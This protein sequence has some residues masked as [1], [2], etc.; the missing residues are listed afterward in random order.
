MAKKQTIV[1]LGVLG[2]AAVAA[3]GG[4]V[5][6]TRIQSPADMAAR[7]APPIPSPILV[8]VEK[9]VLSSDVV[10]RGTA[11]FGLPQPISIV[12][13]VLK[14]DAG[15]IATLPLPNTQFREGD[16]LLTASG[17]PLLI[18]QGKLPAYRDMVPGIS[19]E[20]VR[21]L[22][23]GLARLGFYHGPIDGVYTPQTSVAVAKWYRSK[24]RDPF[25]ST[26]D[27]LV[28]VSTLE[29]AWADA[30][31]SELTAAAAA[32]AAV[33]AVEA[34]RASAERNNKAAAAELAAKM[35]DQ[36]RFAVNPKTGMPLGVEAARAASDEKN[37]AAAAE[38]EA[39]I[40]E[41]ALIALDPRQP[42]TT[43][44]AADA[45][46][47]VARAML[48]STQLDGKMAVQAA[49]R[50]V[51]LVAEQFK[52]AE[53]AVKSVR[54]DGEMAVRSAVNALKVAQFDAK[55]TADRTNR[56][57]ADLA[58]AR[59]KL[60]VQVPVD[61]IVFIPELPVR[62]KEVTA[63]VGDPAKGTVLSVTDNKLAI[64]SSLPI[65]TAP[66]VKP[67]MQ[68]AI[69]EQALGVKAKGVVEM[70]ADTPGTRGVDG[71]HIYFAVR[72]I[73]TSTRQLEGF[74]VRLTIPVKST[75]G[76]VTVVP[77]SALSL[78]SD[79]KSRVQVK[80]KGALEYI[81]VQP[82][83]SADGYVEVIPVDRTLEPGQLVVVGYENPGKRTS[84]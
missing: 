34:A 84:P 76:A 19:G 60:G 39:R 78:A 79:G 66:L 47:E 70:V 36:R 69:D 44:K 26:P 40:A 10:T 3:V 38:L 5:A 37:R 24:G 52:L 33:P 4:W 68:V 83:L 22:Q 18:L 32:T 14:K 75:G 17:R 62:V 1:L 48:R 67:G 12:P 9:R 51:K 16:V 77:I 63:H 30:K 45:K 54:L 43:R 59:R 35:A 15:L 42:A 55:V 29:L 64:D 82:G 7:A 41:R 49:E 72:V 50:D 65:D 81:V 61:E 53:A 74:S 25:G 56:L 11:R 57:A 6:S 20:D 58:K 13:S 8:P 80:N 73:E 21:Q 28:A 31:K 23:Q 71:Y 27:Q 2:F 46:V